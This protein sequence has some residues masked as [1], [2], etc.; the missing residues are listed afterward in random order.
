MSN[1]RKGNGAAWLDFLATRIGRYRQAQTEMLPDPEALQ[2]WL[3]EQDLAPST[4][5]NEQ[6]LSRAWK[7]RE[8]LHAVARSALEKTAPSR[9]ALVTIEQA[10]ADDKPLR[11]RPSKSGLRTARPL[12]AA[13]A[14]ARLARSAVSE[15]GG[16]QRAHLRACAD[17]TCAGI[18]IDHTGRRQWCSDQL[19]GNRARVRAHRERARAKKTR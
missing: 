8:A 1:F 10:L 9:A 6:D 3:S 17:E 14:L 13:E 11:M 4:A 12:T 2:A 15:L 19:C 5:P 7:L 18:F 16:P